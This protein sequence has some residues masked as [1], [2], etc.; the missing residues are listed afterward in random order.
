MQE[1]YVL[2]MAG[3]DFILE[4]NFIKIIKCNLEELAK[5]AVDR[6]WIISCE[7]EIIGKDLEGSDKCIG[8]FLRIYK[9]YERELELGGYYT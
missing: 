2:S 8:I 9:E 6:S 7:G 4:K 5:G 1:K 3:G